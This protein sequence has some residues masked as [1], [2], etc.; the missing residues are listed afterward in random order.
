MCNIKSKLFKGKFIHSSKGIQSLLSELIHDQYKKFYKEKREK[1]NNKE[2]SDDPENSLI[3]EDEIDDD[4]TDFIKKI[5]HENEVKKIIKSDEHKKSIDSFANPRVKA[6]KIKKQTET[7]DLYNITSSLSI[8]EEIKKVDFCNSIINE[9]IIRREEGKIKD[10]KEDDDDVKDNKK[11]N[12]VKDNI[13]YMFPSNK[14]KINYFSS[15][16]L[17]ISDVN[18]DEKE[19]SLFDI[20]TE[21]LP[22]VLKQSNNYYTTYELFKCNLQ[23]ILN[24]SI[25]VYT[26]NNIKN[27]LIQLKQIPKSQFLDFPICNVIRVMVDGGCRGYDKSGYIGVTIYIN[28]TNILQITANIGESCTNNIAEYYSMITGLILIDFIPFSD[29]INKEKF[30]IYFFADSELVIKQINKEYKVKNN[31]ISILKS[32]VSDLI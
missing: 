31:G 1:E 11:K 23:I 14:Y 12:K 10:F 8:F 19:L 7:S 26:A 5:E 22:N 17:K 20:N 28:D 32:T 2:D 30:L 16:L 18:E 3:I 6:E 21:I 29:F 4:I 25:K 9:K 27:S 15:S 24:H 13:L